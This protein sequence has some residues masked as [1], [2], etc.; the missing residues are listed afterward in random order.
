VAG[1]ATAVVPTYF[2]ELSPISIRGAVGT[3]HQL[4][5]TVGIVILQWLS[6]PSLNIFGSEEKWQVRRI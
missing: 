6:T 5:I 3:M 1:I 4:G 2:S